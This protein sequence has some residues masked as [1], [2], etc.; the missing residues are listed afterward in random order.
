M[1]AQGPE[2][3]WLCVSFDVDQEGDDLMYLPMYRPTGPQEPGGAY[4][5][6]G[7]YAGRV[8]LHPGDMLHVVVLGVR[9]AKQIQ[10]S[11]S[12]TSKPLVRVTNCVLKFD[13]VDHSHD[14]SPFSESDNEH[15]FLH[16]GPVGIEDEQRLTAIFNSIANFNDITPPSN[17]VWHLGTS[18]GLPRVRN[19]PAI[20]RMS[21]ILIVA[22]DGEKNPRKFRFDPEAQVGTGTS[23]EQTGQ[24]QLLRPH[25]GGFVRA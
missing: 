11:D 24:N 6:L 18:E 10:V 23:N 8:L 15:K 7:K 3:V 9:Q 5:V 25:D 16:W 20:W 19:N 4:P 2:D 17:L 22:I 13:N 21:L 1:T 14:D 12:S